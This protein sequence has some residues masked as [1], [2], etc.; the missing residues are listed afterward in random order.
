MARIQQ[1][2]KAKYC[3]KDQMET[4]LKLE[5]KIDT[6]KGQLEEL[7]ESI[8]VLKKQLFQRFGKKFR[9]LILIGNRKIL[10]LIDIKGH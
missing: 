4:N 2:I 7:S 1:E 3:E 9:N 5:S 8:K 6:Q 10:N